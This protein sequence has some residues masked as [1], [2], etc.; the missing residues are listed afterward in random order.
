MENLTGKLVDRYQILELLGKGGMAMVYKARDTRLE[1]EVALKIIRLEAFPPEELHDILKRFEREAKASAG[2]SHPNI[3][4]V[5]D[6]GEYK[7]SPFL[8]LEYLPGGTLK[9]QIGKPMSWQK[10]MQLLIP[11]ARGLEYAHQRG[12]IHRDIKPANILLTENGEPTLSDFGIVKL[13]R[14]GET[15]ALTASGAAIGTPE[16]MAPE[17]WTGETGPESDMY[18]L[19]VVLYE[20]IT[21]QRPY[22]ADTP[23]G[24]FLK[25]VTEPLPLPRKI[26]R[27]LPEPVEHFLVKTLEK[28]PSQRYDDLGVFVREIEGL[29]AEYTSHVQTVEHKGAEKAAREKA[30]RDEALE[31]A[32]REAAEMPGSRVVQKNRDVFG[33]LKKSGKSRLLALIPVAFLII[34][35]VILFA[36]LFSSPVFFFCG[37]SNNAHVCEY[38]KNKDE[39]KTLFDLED[40]IHW[41]PVKSLFG[42]IYFTS[43]RDGDTE[44][45]RLKD[46]GEIERV[47]NTAGDAKSWS[48]AVR[49]DGTMYFTSNRS[50][51]AEIY[52][53]NR[54]G[55]VER[56]TNTPGEYES[57]SPVVGFGTEIYFTSDRAGKAEIYRIIGNGDVERV[58]TTTGGYKSW[59]PAYM[60]GGDIYF[61]SDRDGKSEIYRLDGTGGVERVTNTTGISGSWSPIIRGR[62]VYFTSS[63]S[64]QTQVYLLKSQ[65]TSILSFEGWTNVNEKSP[66]FKKIADHST[67]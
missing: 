41:A 9:Q 16:Y 34:L 44:I 35:G 4:K 63:R 67:P 36:Q 5:L 55:D 6:Y 65:V 2:L 37:S 23:G 38:T 48:S 1:R 24:L 61:T 59:A 60:L 31:E 15:T 25:Q 47:T 46:N 64:G 21:G 45:Y 52:R 22:D 14:S 8:V 10:A 43:D 17:Q 58:T 20:I 57:W 51:K 40:A 66:F 3:V 49:Y 11:V 50:G 26:V 19:G 56:V 18:S 62:N 13:F 53:L 42:G 7:G 12:I 54:N 39:I 27:D 30:E 29:L 28:E 33:L 32:A